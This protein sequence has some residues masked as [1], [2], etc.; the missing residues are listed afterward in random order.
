MNNKTKIEK[1]KVA[2]F[3]SAFIG[4]KASGT[5]QAA[6]KIVENLINN[7]SADIQVVLLAKNNYEIELIRNEKIFADQKVILLPQVRGNFLKSSRQ[8]YKYCLNNKN[9]D[10]DILHY[11][12]PRVY[13]FYWF[14]PA[15]KIVCTF[16]AGG[17]VTAP[18]DFFS[19]SR[20]VYNLIIKLQWKKFAAIV[21]DSEFASNEISTAYKIH[22]KYITK[23]YLGADSL[24][25]ELDEEIKR[26][27]NL[28]LIIGRWQKYKNIHTVI[29]AFKNYEVTKNNKIKLKVI[30]KSGQKDNKFILDSL[31]DFP[32]NQIE[33]IEYLS[34]YELA[35]E[36][37]KASV[38]FHPS[39][40]EGFGLPAFEAFGEGA[41]VVA[42]SGTPADEILNTQ[43]GVIF[44]NMLDEKTVIESYRSILHEKFGD[45]T[46]RRAFLE[47]VNA[48]W[49]ASTKKYVEL[50]KAILNSN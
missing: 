8:F 10:L 5:A 34:D 25:S 26:D 31:K 27:S 23:I 21:A 36:Y 14:F 44:Q 40:N 16:H 46:G 24:W 13:P 45:I 38:V 22:H 30:G 9:S 28:V 11:S 43:S 1:I 48:T 49:A 32:L 47:S 35:R 37:R 50:Y 42:H 20:E 3:A 19:I 18:R 6:R 2:W 29:N 17:D 33:I 4:R 15:K 39:I 7:H 41:R 12:V